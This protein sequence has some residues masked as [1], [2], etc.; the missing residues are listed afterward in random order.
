MNAKGQVQALGVGRTSITATAAIQPTVVSEP[1]DLEVEQLIMT[2]IVI[3]PTGPVEMELG[4]SSSFHASAVFEH[5]PNVDVTAQ[6]TW[7]TSNSKA[8]VSNK[9]MHKGLVSA[10]EEGE[11]ELTAT[12][13]GLKS[14]PVKIT[15]VKPRT[16]IPT[17]G[18]G[19]GI[20]CSME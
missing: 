13:N 11:V 10:D 19:S 18:G 5:G 4:R 12:L 2:D 3:T 15:I 20:I 7:A 17:P 6:V 8:S 14:K 1:L 9:L 16:S